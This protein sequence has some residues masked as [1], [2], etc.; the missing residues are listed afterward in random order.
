MDHQYLRKKLKF[1]RNVFFGRFTGLSPVQEEAMPLVLEGKNV[2]LVSSTAS[3]K[4]E[5]VIAP[6]VERLL[7][8]KWKDLSILY[9]SPTRALV[10]DIYNRLKDQVLDLNLTISIKT[11]DRNTFKPHKPSS[12]LITTPESWDSFICRYPAIFKSLK[13]VVIDEIH[14]LDNNYRGDQVRILLN[15]T[16]K[17]GGEF[18]TYILSATVSSPE[19]VAYR[20]MKDPIVVVVPGKRDIR[21][22]FVESFYEVFDYMK[23]EGLKKTLIFC[24]KRRSVEEIARLWKRIVGERN[25]V[26]HHGSLSKHVRE[27]TELFMRESKVG[28]CVST[29]T[30][31]IGID[32]GD[33]D[34][35]VLAD[36]PFTLSSLLQ[37]IG[38]ANRRQN[39]VRV[40]ALYK[41]KK[42]RDILEFMFSLAE[43]GQTEEVIYVPDYSVV[44]QQVFSSLFAKRDGLE[45]GYFREIFDGFCPEEIVEEILHHLEEKGWI[46]FMGNKW[47]GTQKLIDLNK[48]GRIHSNIPDAKEFKVVNIKDRKILGEISSSSHFLESVFILAGR[49]WEIVN[50]E[51]YTIYVRPI[52]SLGETPRFSLFFNEGAFAPFLPEHLRRLKRYGLGH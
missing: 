9:I 36:I 43:K 26:V 15:R 13:A 17:I 25:V 12:L 20:Y 46:V 18:N 1:V 51:D 32:I 3:G 21:Y 4:T 28:V 49:A 27:E 34:A 5:A 39:R 11:G 42:E 40:F 14:F 48:M 47:H 52:R 33:I 29:M 22:S 45:F 2:A 44:V 50:R 30:L 10:N 38:R 23:K 7:E 37:R 41:S 16:R 19:E 24:N 6:L 31:E 35:V 8:E